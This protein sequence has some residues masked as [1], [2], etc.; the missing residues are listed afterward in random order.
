MRR[1]PRRRSLQWSAP[2]AG[3][4][5]CRPPQG[6]CGDG[7]CGTAQFEAP[8]QQS[9]ECNALRTTPHRVDREDGAARRTCGLGIK[10]FLAMKMKFDKLSN[11]EQLSEF[12]RLAS[13]YW[14]CIKAADS[15]GANANVR[16]TTRLVDL[17]ERTHVIE[18]NLTPLLSSDSEQVRLSAAGYL[19]TFNRNERAIE[20]L[21]NLTME[22]K[23]MVDHSAAALLRIHRIEHVARWMKSN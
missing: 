3:C 4:I 19:V 1:V 5:N 10:S 8:T 2:T 22:S 18:S 20:V 16:S 23:T 15:A 21:K 12:V 17:W 13:N 9:A 6:D 11:E 14:A 7:L